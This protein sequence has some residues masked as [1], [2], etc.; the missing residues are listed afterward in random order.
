MCQDFHIMVGL[1][2]HYGD[3][4]RGE[5]EK[6]TIKQKGCRTQTTEAREA[7]GGKGSHSSQCEKAMCSDTVVKVMADIP[8]KGNTG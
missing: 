7:N 5:T 4:A 6:T 8:N 3:E 1:T 2:Y